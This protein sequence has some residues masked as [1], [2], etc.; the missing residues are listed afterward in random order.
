MKN[1]TDNIKNAECITNKKIKT[2]GCLKKQIPKKG[3][4]P[5]KNQ[6]RKLSRYSSTTP[7]SW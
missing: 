2:G 7:E 4:K 6:T 5:L 3:R 1:P